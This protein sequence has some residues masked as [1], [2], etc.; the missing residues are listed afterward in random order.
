LTRID[1]KEAKDKIVL[2]IIISLYLRP[3][4]WQLYVR[5]VRYLLNLI[6]ILKNTQKNEISNSLR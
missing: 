2:K 6:Q 3:F 1:G 5:A 4:L